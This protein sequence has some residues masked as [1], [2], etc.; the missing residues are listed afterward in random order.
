MQLRAN[1]RKESFCLVVPL[2]NNPGVGFIFQ[3]FREWGGEIYR[4]G[5]GLSVISQAP[6]K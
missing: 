1:L 5:E 6:L 2:Q 4:K 3:S